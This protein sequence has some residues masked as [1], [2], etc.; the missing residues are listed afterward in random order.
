MR[1]V[2]PTEHYREWGNEVNWG[3]CKMLPTENV[4]HVCIHGDF[5]AA[6]AEQ[7]RRFA[8]WMERAARYLEQHNGK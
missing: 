1:T 5:A 7:L 8:K 4:A 3:C 2:R 6:D